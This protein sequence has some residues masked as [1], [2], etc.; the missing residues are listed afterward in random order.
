MNAIVVHGDAT[1]VEVAAVLAVVLGGAA[2]ESRPAG[3]DRWRSARLRAL[4]RE[5]REDAKFAAV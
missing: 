5:R 3:Y 2:T 1:P 4:H